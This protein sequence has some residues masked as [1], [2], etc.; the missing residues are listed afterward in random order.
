MFWWQARLSEAA[1]PA[2][3][4]GVWLHVMQS[5]VHLLQ[6]WQNVLQLWE[7]RTIDR[8]LHGRKVRKL[9][10]MRRRF[11]DRSAA[12]AIFLHFGFDKYGYLPYEVFVQSLNESPARLLGHE[13][14]LDK[15]LTGKNGIENMVDVA[16]L[17]GDAKVDYPKCT[18][19]VFPPSGFDE[20][21]AKRSMKLPRAHM[22]LEHVYGY[23]GA[24]GL[25]SREGTL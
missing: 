1:E 12:A 10:P 8:L 4:A 25:P 16:Y 3:V 23:A 7:Y 20:L 9:Q 18:T 2:V 21:L 11:I 19:G 15:T 14:L 6:V 17:M 5:V 24:Q 22:W 13:L